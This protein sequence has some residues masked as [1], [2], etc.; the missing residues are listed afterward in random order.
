V[1]CVF[2]FL[3]GRSRWPCDPRIPGAARLGRPARRV[4]GGVRVGAVLGGLGAGLLRRRS[5]WVVVVGIIAGWGAACAARAHRP[6][7]A[8][9]GRVRRR[10]TDLRTVHRDLY[11]PVP[12]GQPA[13]MLSRVLAARTALTTRPPPSVRCWAA[14][15]SRRSAAGRPCWLRRCSPSRSVPWWPPVVRLC[16][17]PGRVAPFVAI[18][19]PADT[20]GTTPAWMSRTVRLDRAHH[21]VRPRRRRPAYRRAAAPRRGRVVVIEDGAMSGCYGSSALGHPA[22]GGQ[23]PLAETLAEGRPA[24]AS[25]GDLRARRRP[26]HPGDR[27]AGRQERP[28]YGSSS[29]CAIPRWA[30]RC[31]GSR[32]PSSMWPACP[33]PRW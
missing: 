24:R 26:A 2:F 3:Y 9:A 8:G 4:L 15:W 31:P 16:P 22:P 14:R 5:L 18:L 7:V 32:C 1:T 12:A 11:R 33:R 28:E 27:P 13:R 20:A 30:G 17:Q 23:L 25:C 21:R 10:R 6:G 19:Y 29:S